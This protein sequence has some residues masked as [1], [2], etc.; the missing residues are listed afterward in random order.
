MG[1]NCIDLDANTVHIIKSKESSGNIKIILF[2]TIFQNRQCYQVLL[3]LHC[4]KSISYIILNNI[5]YIYCGIAYG[6]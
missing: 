2:G 3:G 4:I 5:Y 1:G 6:L